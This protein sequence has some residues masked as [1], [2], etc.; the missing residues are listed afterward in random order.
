MKLIQTAFPLTHTSI[1]QHM[2]HLTHF[3]LLY[4]A[5]RPSS[6]TILRSILNPLYLP[7]LRVLVLRL[8][9]NSAGGGGEGQHQQQQQQQQ[10]LPPSMQLWK[11]KKLIMQ[12]RAVASFLRYCHN[13]EHFTVTC[14]T[15]IWSGYRVKLT[16]R[17][18]LC[19]WTR[20]KEF[21]HLRE[22]NVDKA[23]Y[24][25]VDDEADEGLDNGIE[26]ACWRRMANETDKK[27]GIV[28]PKCTLYT[29]VDT[30]FW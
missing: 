26:L 9:E 14:P 17:Q 21:P 28:H 23:T 29:A 2:P 1:L 7:R 30:L 12:G 5:Q 25:R 19:L 15:G 4:S 10:Q 24:V 20:L 18:R 3:T 8:P 22:I 13:L 11:L 27:G 6:Q 16:P